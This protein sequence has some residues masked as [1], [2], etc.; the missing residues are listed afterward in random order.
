MTMTT[1]MVSDKVKQK[2]KKKKNKC[3]WRFRGVGLTKLTVFHLVMARWLDQQTE[4]AEEHAGDNQGTE[5][6]AAATLIHH[7]W[8]PS[9]R[10]HTHIHSTETDS[11]TTSGQVWRVKDEYK[12]KVVLVR[13]GKTK[14]QMWARER[15][16]DT[17]KNYSINECAFSLCNYEDVSAKEGNE[18]APWL[19]AT[20]D[21]RR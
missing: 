14:R 11:Q 1:T 16:Y 4:E 7:H 10:T 19:T 2:K 21:D 20:T 13:R 6:A 9:T 8:D 5:T 17:G 3:W 18:R 15:E 12:C